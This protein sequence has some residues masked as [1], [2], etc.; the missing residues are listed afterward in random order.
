MT[1]NT[2]PVVTPR[3][4]SRIWAKIGENTAYAIGLPL[5]LIVIWGI[6]ATIAP[7]HMRDMN[8]TPEVCSP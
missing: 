3:P 2:S 7:A 5:I 4:R 6:W 8:A 1:L